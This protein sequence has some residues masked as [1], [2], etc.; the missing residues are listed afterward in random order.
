MRRKGDTA[1]HPAFFI[2][3]AVYSTGE[4]KRERRTEEREEKSLNAGE[5]IKQ[6]HLAS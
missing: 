1:E 2:W 6:A 3:P 4:T 5:S